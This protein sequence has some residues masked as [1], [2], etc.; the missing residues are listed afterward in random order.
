MQASPY[1]DK[2]F[3]VENSTSN[4]SADN[5]LLYYLPTWNKTG[6]CLV[7]LIPNGQIQ[8]QLDTQ[9]YEFWRPN[10]QIWPQNI[11]LAEDLSDGYLHQEHLKA[12]QATP[13]P[14]PP[15]SQ[16]FKRLL[17]YP[18]LKPSYWRQLVSQLSAERNYYQ[19]MLIRPLQ[20]CLRPSVIHTYLPSVY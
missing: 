5:L 2:R 3:N 7:L 9:K 14:I 10:R 6:N 16:S 19:E 8:Q 15:P 11:A 13:Y 17:N 18:G 4:P 20:Y 12:G 1:R